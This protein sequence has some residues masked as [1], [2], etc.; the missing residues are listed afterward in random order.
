[1]EAGRKDLKPSWI[2]PLRRAEN[3]IKTP[4]AWPA[5][6]PGGNIAHLFFPDDTDIPL[7]RLSLADSSKQ[8]PWRPTVHKYGTNQEF[9]QWKK[10]VHEG[11]LFSCCQKAAQKHGWYPSQSVWRASREALIKSLSAFI[12]E[13]LCNA[14]NGMTQIASYLRN[15][16]TQQCRKILI[17]ADSVN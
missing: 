16:M 6:H 3:S 8:M 9:L 11:L 4:E 7:R 12:R 1:M 17:K 14:R 13:F 5:R 2:S 10:A 15:P